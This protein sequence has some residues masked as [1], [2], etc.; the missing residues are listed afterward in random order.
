MK[1]V[2]KS[3][4]PLFSKELK[5]ENGELSLTPLFYGKAQYSEPLVLEV[6]NQAGEVVQLATL[7]VSSETGRVRLSDKS[8]P[9]TPKVEQKGT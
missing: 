3:A 1:I 5:L 7:K 8:Q 6:H 9:V 2:I 4:G